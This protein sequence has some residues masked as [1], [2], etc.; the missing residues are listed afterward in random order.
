MFR[1]STPSRLEIQCRSFVLTWLTVNLTGCGY[2]CCIKFSG[3][4]LHKKISEILPLHSGII[5]VIS[6]K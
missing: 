2:N 5:V 1:R 4:F 3:R 6:N